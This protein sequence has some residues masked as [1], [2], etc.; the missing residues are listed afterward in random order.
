M[1]DERFLSW[2][3]A[4]NL[5]GAVAITSATASKTGHTIRI[6][7]GHG[8]LIVEIVLS[9][10]ARLRNHAGL[11]NALMSGIKGEE[12]ILIQAALKSVLGRCVSIGIFDYCVFATSAI[13]Q[14]ISRASRL[15]G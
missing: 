7:A 6:R 11:P 8:F 1:D 9:C 5:P 10:T 12:A 2:S 4:R 14:E 3:I 13:V 15:V